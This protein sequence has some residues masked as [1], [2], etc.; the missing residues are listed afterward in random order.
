MIFKKFLPQISCKMEKYTDLSFDFVNF[1]A[2]ILP[3][4]LFTPSYLHNF[5][6]LIIK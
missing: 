5:N 2:N 4:P 6:N 3:S 1:T